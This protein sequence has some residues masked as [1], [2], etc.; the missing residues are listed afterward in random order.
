MPLGKPGGPEDIDQSAA[1]EL[2]HKFESFIK[3]CVVNAYEVPAA[4][5]EV[6]HGTAHSS[7][8]DPSVFCFVVFDRLGNQ[9]Y[10]VTARLQDDG[11]LSDYRWGKI[12]PTTSIP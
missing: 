9:F 11:T 10:G 2:S 8:R 4:N 6:I 1:I 12:H 7:D 3:G 5:L